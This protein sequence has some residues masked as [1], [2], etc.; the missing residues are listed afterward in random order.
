MPQDAFT[1]RLVAKELNEEL[2]GGRVNKINQPDREEVSLVIYTGKR[3]VKL[4]VNANAS[5]CGVYFCDDDRENPL[6]APNFCMLLRKHLQGA[7]ILGV[8]MVG[9]ERIL[10]IRFL[11]LSD[12]SS[13]ERELCVEVMGK[14]SNVLLLERDIIL[15]AMKTTS[16]D[17]NR[18]RVILA[19]AKYTLPAPQDKVDPRDFAALSRVLSAAE[20]DRARY[21]FTRVA[22]LAPV[23]A[24]QIAAGDTGGDFARYVY[25]Y[26][27]S[28]EISP[29][30]TESDFFARTVAGAVPYPTLSAA[31]TAFYRAKRAKKAEDGLKRRL[32]SAI[33]AALKKH[34]KRLAQEEEKR[35][36][37]ALAEENRKKGE[38]LT[39]NLWRLPRGEKSCEL[40]DYTDGSAVKI[41]LDARL[42]PAENAQAYFKKYRKQKRALEILDAQEEETRAEIGSLC[43]LRAAVVSADGTEDLLCAEEELLLAGLLKSPERDGR[44]KKTAEYPFRVYEKDGFTVR[45][46]RNN[47]QNE[48]LVRLS[49]PE[50]IWFHA[51]RYHSCHVVVRTEGREV[52]RAVLQ[53]AADVCAKYSDGGGDRVAVDYCPV[54]RVKKPAGAKA[55][56]VTYTDHETLLGDPEHV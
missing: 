24:E 43:A 40:T 46:G 54:R 20:G 47:L 15:G 31:Q 30:A 11:C 19:G 55:G 49:A 9:F 16:L 36:D 6:N 35:R 10:K 21:L 53:F 1:L 26:I 25:D 8:S 38:L 50:D 48:R 56:F 5:D 44:R 33:S 32:L 27:F 3:T 23:T 13:C 37:C 39:A 28:D 29:C 2:T 7:Q 42:S 14:Y 4:V 34:E 22:G 41:S 17:E 45:A 51:Q 18:R 52:P 12:F